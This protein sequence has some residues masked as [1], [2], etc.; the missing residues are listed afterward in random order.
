MA[1]RK[2][3][4]HKMIDLQPRRGR[5]PCGGVTTV[6]GRKFSLAAAL[7]LVACSRHS[8]SAGSSGRADT[9]LA[10]SSGT[11]RS[12]VVPSTV[13]PATSA[14]PTNSAAPNPPLVTTSPS[15]ELRVD[16]RG[17]ISILSVAAGKLSFCDT[18]GLLELE[19]PS[20]RVLGSALVCPPVVPP[21]PTIPEVTVR[22]PDLGPTDILEVDGEG[23]SFPL[24]GHGRDWAADKQRHVVVSTATRV[25]E[26]NPKTG[27][28]VTLSEQGAARVAV[29]G[30]WAA[31]WDG[32]TVVAHRL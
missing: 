14:T 11:G 5:Q 22:T 10:T 25:I 16:S 29:G 3:T 19:L 28:R 7:L 17:E 1:R 21:D 8:P 27:K 32:T 23:N 31:W 26:L 18:G 20:G 9:A 13:A 12:T 4:A 2:A 24:D 6:K 15:G 30:G